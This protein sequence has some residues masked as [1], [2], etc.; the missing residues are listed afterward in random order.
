MNFF[1]KIK[2]NMWQRLYG[3]FPFFH[4]NFH[5]FYVFFHGKE[6]QRYHIGWLAPGKTLDELKKHLQE[7]WNFGNNFVAWVDLGQVLSWRKLESFHRQHHVRVFEDGEIRGH[8]E[9]TPESH[10]LDHFLEKGELERKDDFLKFLGSFVVEQKH[11]SKLVMDPGAFI[12]D[13]QV[14]IDHIK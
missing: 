1:D 13:S 2:H 9:F 8:Y 12:S 4:K 3:F 5:K 11:V 7:K 6:R 14:T 10:P